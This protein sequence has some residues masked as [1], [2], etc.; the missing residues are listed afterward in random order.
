M[1]LKDGNNVVISIG[2]ANIAYDPNMRELDPEWTKA[3][4]G[5]NSLVI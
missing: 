3:I 2:G 5:G 1:Q 4:Q